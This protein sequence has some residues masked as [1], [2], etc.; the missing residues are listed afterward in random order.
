MHFHKE[1]EHAMERGQTMNQYATDE[2]EIVLVYQRRGSAK[3][4]ATAWIVGG[5]VMIVAAGLG[6]MQA[7]LAEVGPIKLQLMATVPALAGVGAL[8]RGWTGMRAPQCVEIS[9]DALAVVSHR[10]RRLFRWEELGWSRT[11]TGSMGGK[12]LLIYDRRGRR[13]ARLGAEIER[14]SELAEEIAQRIAARNG[15]QVVAGVKLK[16]GRQ[17]AVIAVAAAVLF[18]ALGI[19]MAW[20]TYETQRTADLLATRGVAGEA[21]VLRWFVAPNGVTTRV[22]YRVP[23]QD[24]Q[25]N[26]EV[27]KDV[28]AER[29]GRT[30]VPVI[31]VPEEPSVSRLAFGEVPAQTPGG[32]WLSALAGVMALGMLVGAGFA[33]RGKGV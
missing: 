15:E 3:A 14:L 22:E 10:A 23:G 19:F 28:W 18:L 32:Y 31:Y 12:T 13:R 21:E 25:Q 24:G 1:D 9:E 17:A 16:K 4:T 26:V 27:E 30:R 33:W 11:E 7:V 20:E 8:W 29:R 2:S 6:F 5:V